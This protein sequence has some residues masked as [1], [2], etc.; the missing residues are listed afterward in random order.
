MQ[1]ITNG[2]YVQVRPLTSKR[3]CSL[4]LTEMEQDIGLPDKLM[5]DQ[6]AEVTDKN[7]NWMKEINHL[8]I[9]M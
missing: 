7:T 6:V 1:V 5:A 4:L 8:K 3:D 9:K 2:S